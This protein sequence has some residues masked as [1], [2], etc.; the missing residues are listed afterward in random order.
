MD[1]NTVIQTAELAGSV[2]QHDLSIWGLFMQADLIVKTVMIMLMGASVWS[3]AI[4]FD[5]WMM[6]AKISSRATRFENYFWSGES[7][8]KLYNRIKDTTTD[9]MAR[10]FCAGM[11]EWKLSLE[12]GKTTYDGNLHAGLQQRI[13]RA[14]STTINREMGILERYMSFLGTVGS[15]APFIGLFGTVWGIMNS[16]SA[17]AGS[18]NTS[19]AVVAP[20]IAEA[21]FATAMGLVA[22]IPAVI[23]YNKFST[24]LN[25]YAD[26]LE[27]FTAEF[28]SILSRHFEKQGGNV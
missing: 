5:K 8:E 28:S 20:G 24:D 25:R 19:L 23:A 7:L 18:Q 3:W 22:A 13:E 12:T 10:T 27:G 17:I 26:R 15:T 14:M 16:F 11:H 21:L 6:F 1:A 9:P 2:A 4:M